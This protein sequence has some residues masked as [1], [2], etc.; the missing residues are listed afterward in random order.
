MLAFPH[1]L[2]PGGAKRGPEI[3][4]DVVPFPTKGAVVTAERL[5]LRSTALV[6]EGG[7]MVVTTPTSRYPL[8]EASRGWVCVGLR[9]DGGFLLF[10]SSPRPDLYVATTSSCRPLASFPDGTLIQWSNGV[11]HAGCIRRENPRATVW[12][13]GVPTVLDSRE[14]PGMVL[15]ISCG[16]NSAKMDFAVGWSGTP[17]RAT[18]WREGGLRLLPLPPGVEASEATKA[19]GAI[20]L[21]GASEVPNADGF[22]IRANAVLRWSPRGVETLRA[23]RTFGRV[24]AIFPRALQGMTTVG[25]L[26][27]G[28]RRISEGFVDRGGNMRIVPTIGGYVTTDVVGIDAQGVLLCSGGTSKG[29]AAFLLRPR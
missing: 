21:G 3:R 1:A 27:R 2:G 23:P 28:E 9:G 7:R 15:A 6:T 25:R 16:H 10:A 18:I 14:E 8:P 11:L 12:R 19:D 20:V 29:T 5:G 24:R 13:N 17:S 4:Y 26:Y 22:P